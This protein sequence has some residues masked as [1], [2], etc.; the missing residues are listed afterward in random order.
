MQIIILPSPKPFGSFGS[1]GFPNISNI[2]WTVWLV[3]IPQ[4]FPCAPTATKSTLGTQKAILVPG[5]FH[6][7]KLPPKVAISNSFGNSVS[8]VK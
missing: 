3:P 2:I 6:H 8:M 1:F 7:R 4:T 5:G